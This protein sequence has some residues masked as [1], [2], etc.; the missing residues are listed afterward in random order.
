MR[1]EEKGE[2]KYAACAKKKDHV[3][4]IAKTRRKLEDTHHLYEEE[5]TVKGKEKEPASEEIQRPVTTQLLEG[6]EREGILPGEEK[7]KPG[8]EPYS[9]PIEQVIC[10]VWRA[11]RGKR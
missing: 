4:E 2:E 11:Q 1:A 3:L 6:N 9:F 5:G 7:R 8:D 10:T